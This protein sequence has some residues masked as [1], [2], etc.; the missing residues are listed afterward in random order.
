LTN[1]ALYGFGGMANGQEWSSRIYATG[2]IT[3]A[4]AAAAIHAAWDALWGDIQA[5]L[6]AASTLTESAAYTVDGTWHFETV[7]STAEALAGTS[8]SESMP[9]STCAVLTWRTGR[10]TKKGHGRSFLP[11]AAV[12]AIATAADTGQLLPAFRTACTTGGIAFKAALTGAGL[13]PVLLNRASL[14]TTNITTINTGVL[15]RQQRRR[16]SKVANNYA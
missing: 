5:Y 15:F 9:I 6:P 14:T 16:Q 3:E 1:F 10:P 13:A 8:A 2:S 7:T 12:N 11:P 4:A